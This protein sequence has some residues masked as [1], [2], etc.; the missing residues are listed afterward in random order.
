MRPWL[1]SLALLGI[2]L[3]C[4]AQT[5]PAEFDHDR[6]RL[7]V[8]ADDGSTLRFYTD[9]GG[10]YNAIAQPAA[11][12]LKLRPTGKTD[13]DDG[14]SFPL[15]DFPAFAAKAGVPPPLPDAWL[16]GKLAVAP[17]DGMMGDDGVLGSRWFAGRVWRIDYGRREMTLLHGWQPAAAD[18]ETTLG[19]QQGPDG[20]RRANMPRVTITVDGQPLE[21]LLDTGAAIT[22]TPDSAPVFGVTPGAQVGGGFMMA[23]VFEAW[24]AKHPDWRVVDRA[25]RLQG[26]GLPMIEV[27][28]VTVAG[29]T[30][31]P[32]W[33]ARRPDINFT[34]MMS[35]MTDKPVVG[36][37]GGSG[38][39]YFRVVLDYPGARAW[40]TP[41]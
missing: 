29:V 3:P 23:S 10:G 13:E 18:H 1:L 7:V 19:F 28:H 8:H 41:N 35:S 25:D 15:V 6:I 22:T 20:T 32:V 33:F 30:V 5:L 36:A 17:P 9:S 14:P 40:F 31:G 2:A 12:R 34:R 37:F 24:R 16:N 26:S 4:T 21:V 11:E 27:P 39:R 38:L